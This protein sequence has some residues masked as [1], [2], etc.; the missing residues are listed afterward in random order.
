MLWVTAYELNS[1]FD[2]KALSFWD[3]SCNIENEMGKTTIRNVYGAR[4]SS[5]ISTTEKQTKTRNEQW[6]QTN[7]W[8]GGMSWPEPI[9]QMVELTNVSR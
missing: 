4:S 7:L 5:Y 3:D 8:L 6:G 2:E 9:S 1:N